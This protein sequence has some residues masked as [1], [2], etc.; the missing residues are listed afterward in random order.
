MAVQVILVP[1][2]TP[3]YV[4]WDDKPPYLVV[5]KVGEPQQVF[6]TF[7][8]TQRSYAFCGNGFGTMLDTTGAEYVTGE[9]N[10]NERERA[11]NFLTS[12]TN[13]GHPQ[14]SC[15]T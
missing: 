8:S 10:V 15:K 3:L 14:S 9:P 11:M 1:H 13:L 12:T 7:V 2:H 4:S 5:N 6:G